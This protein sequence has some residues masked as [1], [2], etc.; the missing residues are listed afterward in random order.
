[1]GQAI[2]RIDFFCKPNI[3][4]QLNLNVFSESARLLLYYHS[5]IEQSSP[6]CWYSF[7]SSKTCIMIEQSSLPPVTS[8]DAKNAQ[9][10]SKRKGLALKNPF[11]HSPSKTVRKC[12][13]YGPAQ[14][15]MAQ[16]KAASS[17]SSPAAA[18]PPSSG[19]PSA[20]AANT[21]VGAQAIAPS[22]R[23]GRIF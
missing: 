20:N 3:H 5:K 6:C 2:G 23:V 22:M 19:A 12:P 1:L 18:V 11:D 17:A 8:S 4:R 13:W 7:S 14:F 15:V 21:S 9:N 16:A 10:L